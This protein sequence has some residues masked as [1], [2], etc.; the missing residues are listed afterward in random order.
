M[1]VVADVAVVLYQVTLSLL[2]G[3]N[4]NLLVLLANLISFLSGWLNTSSGCIM[5]VWNI[6]SRML[7]SAGH[8]PRKCP[9]VCRQNIV[10]PIYHG[11]GILGI[12]WSPKTSVQEIGSLYPKGYPTPRGSPPGGSLVSHLISLLARVAVA[13]GEVCNWQK[14]TLLSY[15][16]R[17]KIYVMYSH[18]DKCWPSLW[19]AQCNNIE[20]TRN[21]GPTLISVTI[22]MIQWILLTAVLLFLLIS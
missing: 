17:L 9:T 7:Y 13:C 14:P 15:L 10:S 2:V 12:F 1:F 20:C 22:I 19:R 6:S 11:I 4:L 3:S 18:R 5:C 21:E 16:L 8:F